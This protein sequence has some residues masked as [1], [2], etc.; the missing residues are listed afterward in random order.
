MEEHFCHT[1]WQECIWTGEKRLENFYAANIR[2]CGGWVFAI[3]G[4]RAAY[5]ACGKARSDAVGGA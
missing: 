1:V 2:A 3:F 5:G 4:V